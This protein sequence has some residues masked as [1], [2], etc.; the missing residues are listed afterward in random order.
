LNIGR[1]HSSGKN[2]S[3]ERSKA[4]K[5]LFVLVLLA[6]AIMLSGCLAIGNHGDCRNKEITVGQQLL[7]LQKAKEAGALTDAEYQA[8]KAKILGK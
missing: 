5:K 2:K 6:I 8:Q 4:M 7:D 3:H 1:I